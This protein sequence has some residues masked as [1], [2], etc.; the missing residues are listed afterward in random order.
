MMTGPAVHSNSQPPPPPQ[1]QQQQQQELNAAVYGLLGTDGSGKN[2]DSGSRLN[3]SSSSGSGSS[4]RMV[5]PD[6]D[7]VYECIDDSSKSCIIKL[8]N[9]DGVHRPP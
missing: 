9:T 6:S 8:K 1:Q 2:K 5:A 4:S 7:N 3:S